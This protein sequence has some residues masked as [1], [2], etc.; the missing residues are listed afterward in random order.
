MTR[1]LLGSCPQTL[2][3]L[4]MILLFVLFVT[5][6]SK[7]PRNALAGKIFVGNYC[8]QNTKLHFTDLT[9]VDTFSAQHIF[10]HGLREWNPVHPVVN[11]ASWGSSRVKICILA[12]VAFIQSCVWNVITILLVAP[13]LCTQKTCGPILHRATSPQH[14]AGEYLLFYFLSC[15]VSR[16]AMVNFP[17]SSWKIIF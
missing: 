7:I 5:M 9:T 14:S 1:G 3:G 2:L 15:R 12:I 17:V 16:L 8:S 11:L 6:L 4:W 13:K 10:V